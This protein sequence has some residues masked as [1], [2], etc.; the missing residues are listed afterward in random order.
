MAAATLMISSFNKSMHAR[1]IFLTT[2]L[3]C[4]FASTTSA[5]WTAR[6]EYPDYCSSPDAMNQ[7]SI[8]PV[9]NVQQLEGLHLLQV[10]AAIR[11]GSR[12]PWERHDCWNGYQDDPVQSRWDCDLTTVTAPMKNPDQNSSITFNKVYDALS[13]PLTNELSGTCQ[14]GQLLL[15]GR[16]QEERNGQYL[17]NAYLSDVNDDS[18]KLF[19]S[20]H[21]D[22]VPYKNAIYF[23]SDDDQRV[24]M[25]GQVLLESMFDVSEDTMMVVHSK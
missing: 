17:R 11:H 22:E 8:P 10:V 2:V 1:L 15:I 4:S 19:N 25:S 18:M 16:E 13:D 14:K 6:E 24:L 21:Y 20:S 7:R 23:R 5:P 12:T 9:N 3:F